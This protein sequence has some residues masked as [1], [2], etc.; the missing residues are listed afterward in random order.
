MHS[1]S[2]TIELQGR[3]FKVQCF[4]NSIR[5]FFDVLCIN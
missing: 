1:D 5:H 4:K 3:T 2:H